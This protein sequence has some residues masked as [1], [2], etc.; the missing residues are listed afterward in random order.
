MTDRKTIAVIV[1]TTDGFF[2]SKCLTGIIKQAKKLDY[3]V[4]VFSVFTMT[5]NRTKHQLGEENIYELLRSECIAGA[6]IVDYSFWADALKNK[7]YDLIASIPGFRA[8]ILDQ[9]ERNGFKGIIPDDRKGLS[10]VMDHLIEVHGF[11]KIYCLT[12]AAEFY[13]SHIRADGYRDS[14]RKHGLEFSEDYIIFGDF[15]TMAATAL[16]EKIA[17][18]E[19][20]KPEAVVCANDKS[21]STLVNELI[22]RGVRVPDDVAV[23]GYDLGSDSIINDPSVTSC[24]RPDLYT[25]EL[26]ICE[27]HRQITGESVEPKDENKGVFVQ[28]ESCGCRRDVAFAHSFHEVERLENES[29]STF[30]FSCMQESLMASE[31]LEELIINIYSRIYIIRNVS[32]FVLCLNKDWNL[33]RENDDDY[34]RKGYSEDMIEVMF[35]S[36]ES[37]KRNV[38]FNSK[39]LFPPDILKDDRPVA[40]FF[41]AVHF[42]D[43]CFGY[44]VVRFASQHLYRFRCLFEFFCKSFSFDRYEAP[45]FAHE[46]KTIFR[47]DIQFCDSS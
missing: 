26:C 44:Q 47:K 8:V 18:G 33:F 41:N 45:A 4:A 37:E 16:A 46:G 11:R 32:A 36:W 42:E 30:R 43:R 12:G 6:V 13:V 3:N 23:A 7:I 38:P 2:Q 17:N 5:D 15:W 31:T 14:M 35:W 39:D 34:I 1:G 9:E 27:L 10:Q 28:G 20:E 24:T 25:G 29:E 19:I 40:C 22:S 21:A